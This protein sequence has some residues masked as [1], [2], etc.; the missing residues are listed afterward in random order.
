MNKG[1]IKF[2][3]VRGSNPTP[4]IDKIK[5]GGDTSCIEIRTALNDA[6]ILDMGT[7]IRNLGKEIINDPSYPKEINIFLS[8]YHW[9]HI[10]GFLGFAPLFDP[11]F[12]FNMYGKKDVMSPN[13]IM[14]YIQNP[15]FW[16]IDMSML[17]AKINLNEFPSNNLQIDYNINV[18]STPHEHP[19]GA[20]TYRFQLGDTVIVYATDCEHPDNHLN[21]NVIDIAKDTDILIHDAQYKP[22]QIH[23][24]KGWGHSSWKNCVEVAK[25]AKVKQL[26]L[27]H[28]NPEHGN[29]I[30]EGIQQEAQNEFH[31][32]I[33]AK[34]GMEILIPKEVSESVIS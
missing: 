23:N 25:N 14:D 21:Q 13:Q 34:E 32:T 31:N 8:H 22:D 2:W 28:H 19:N 17:N 6:I 3:G 30:L 18:L 26:V 1:Y 5:Y 12:I 20:N 24:H 4:D 11:S 15:T 9:D 27:F 10:F 7:G 16:P 33:S 29:S